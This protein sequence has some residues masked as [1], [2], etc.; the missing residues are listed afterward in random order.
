MF[1]AFSKEQGEVRDLGDTWTQSPGLSDF[2]SIASNERKFGKIK[3][4]LFQ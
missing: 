1:D 3:D 4:L 2:G